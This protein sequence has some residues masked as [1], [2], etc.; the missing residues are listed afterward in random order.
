MVR[1]EMSEQTHGAAGIAALAAAMPTGRLQEVCDIADA[2]LYLA[3]N[4][5]ARLTRVMLDV[6]GGMLMR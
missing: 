4:A 5:G 1:T 6:N 2:C 3:S